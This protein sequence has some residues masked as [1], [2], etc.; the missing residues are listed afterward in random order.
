MDECTQVVNENKTISGL[1]EKLKL[2]ANSKSI[3]IAILCNAFINGDGV[4]RVIEQQA[5]DLKK[6]GHKVTIFALESNQSAPEGIEVINLKAPNNFLINRLYRL[7]FPLDI[8]K[9]VKFLKKLK[10]FDLTISH[11][12]TVAWLSFFNRRINKIPYIYYQHPVT[13]QDVSKSFSIYMSIMIKIK[14]YL[15]KKADKVIAISKFAQ[16]ELR[17]R[18]GVESEILYNK[19]DP[20]FKDYANES[21]IREKHNLERNPI[22]LYVGRVEKKKNVHT[23]IK[24][25][26]LVKKEVPEVK[27]VIVGKQPF[28]SYLRELK[29]I[30]DTSVI[31]TGYVPDEE[32]ASFYAACDV[33]ATCSLY[34]GFDLPVA[35]AQAMGKPVVAFDIGSHKEVLE[36]GYLVEEGDLESFSQKIISTLRGY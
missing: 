27:L 4:S 13:S 15:V 16:E 32:L 29:K 5:K 8:T 17:I 22:I 2:N 36:N 24:A 25:F 18:T 6:A 35:E 11:H 34:E 21:K 9:I 33:Y 23:L 30:G 28:S 14:D 3:R 1:I 12:P 31:F 26:N 10:G 19:I 20:R 7:L